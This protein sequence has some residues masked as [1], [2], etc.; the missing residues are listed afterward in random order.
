MPRKIRL[1]I[2][3]PSLV[4][5]GKHRGLVEEATALESERPALESALPFT[6]SWQSYLTSLRLSFSICKVELKVAT[7]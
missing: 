6:A 4:Y 7:H 3:T 5:L 1:C 2:V